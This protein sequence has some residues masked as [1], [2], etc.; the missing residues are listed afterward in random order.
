MSYDPFSSFAAAFN[1]P[2]YSPFASKT[3]TDEN[4]VEKQQ[5][6]AAKKLAHRKKISFQEAM[7][8]VTQPTFVADAIK[9]KATRVN[10]E[11]N[12]CQSSGMTAQAKEIRQEIAKTKAASVTS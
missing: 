6:T 1:A 2:S 3:P 12:W 11:A 4:I 5:R 8:I 10:P 9:K 7:V